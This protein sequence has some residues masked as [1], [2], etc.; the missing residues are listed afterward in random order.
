MEISPRQSIRF[1]P[2]EGTVAWI[3]P[4]LREH[5]QDFNPIL[6]ALVVDEAQA[7]C[8]LVVL[9]RDWLREDIQCMVRIGNM[10]PLKG[11]VRWLRDLGEG[12]VK[13]GVEYLD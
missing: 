3:D 2:D 11:Q 7:G 4:T 13:V 8:G 10:T 1:A 12:V 6:A 5:W 9:A